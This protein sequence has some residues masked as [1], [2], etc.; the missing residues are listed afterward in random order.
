M[1]LGK[2]WTILIVAQVSFAVAILPPAVSSAWENTLDG[3]AGLGF[4]AE[5]F[6]SAQLGMDSVPER[7]AAAA[8]AREFT[9]FAGRQTELI[10]LLEAEPRLSGVTFAM[11]NPGNEG[12]ARIEAEGIAL[13][14]QLGVEA[15]GTAIRVKTEVHEVRFNRV[16]VDFFRVFEV[17]ILGGRGLEP[18]DVASAGEG[19]NLQNPNSPGGGTVVVNQAFAQR[20]FG[21]NALGRRI[22]YVDRSRS[23]ERRKMRSPGAG[24]RSS[25]SPGISPPASARACATPRSRCT[26]R[27]LPARYSPQPSPFGFETALHLPSLN[28]CGRSPWRS[29]PTFTCAIY[30]VWTRSYAA[31]SGSAACKQR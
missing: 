6:L 18:V 9:R 23:V 3:I 1:R 29:I 2:T 30:A 31:S 27:S 28:A 22:R 4:A 12:N 25:V 14:S 10:R 5:E 11:F 8:G 17:P 15:N 13:P 21:G 16:D 7:G 24:T 19:P 20:I 26:T